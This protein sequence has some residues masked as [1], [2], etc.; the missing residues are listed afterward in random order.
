LSSSADDGDATIVKTSERLVQTPLF[1][2]GENGYQSYRIP[3]LVRATDGSLLAFCE[4]RN[5]RRPDRVLQHELVLKRSTDHGKSWSSLQVLVDSQD[6]YVGNACPV[7]DRQTKTVWLP[8]TLG[9][10]R[11]FVISSKNDGQSWS[12]PV[13][14][15]AD[16]KPHA[17][18]TY[19]E[20][21]KDGKDP[22]TFNGRYGTGPTHGIQTST[23]R[24]VIPCWNNHDEKLHSHVI[25][26]DDHGRSWRLGGE[27]EEGDT[28]EC[29]VVELADGRLMLH[30]RGRSKGRAVSFSK[31]GGESWSAVSIDAVLKIEAAQCQANLLRLT[32]KPS[33]DRD[34]LLYS[35]PSGPKRAN[36]TVRL[37]YDEGR[38]W[39]VGKPLFRGPS[40]YSDLVTTEDGFIGCLYERGLHSTW[41]P[42]RMIMFAKFNLEWLSDSSDTL[43]PRVDA[44]GK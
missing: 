28:E 14:I 29:S 19:E 38:T 16:V 6:N 37:S 15:T 40:A 26:S 43:G 35:G 13:E 24:L 39:A 41:T 32:R 11:V 33:D 18:G 36:V 22:K 20:T 34:R 30:A 27:V 4:A 1:I 44:K 2:A 9:N 42:N 23:G 10:N 12:E 5:G 3:A 17:W 7:I 21:R 8:Y 31:D 25:L